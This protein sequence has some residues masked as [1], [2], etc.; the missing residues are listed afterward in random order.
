MNP[1]LKHIS[2]REQLAEYEDLSD[3]TYA[4]NVSSP[5]V[6]VKHRFKARFARN[7]WNSISL[8]EVKT[9]VESFYRINGAYVEMTGNGPGSVK[10][11]L[12]TIPNTYTQSF[13]VTLKAN[14]ITVT[15]S[16]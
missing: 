15:S 1:L 12:G 4:E 7:G 16:K 14:A 10:V 8:D 6:L 11:L 13:T 3:K 5:Q 2:T 9:I